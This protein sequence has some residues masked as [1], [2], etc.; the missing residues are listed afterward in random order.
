[1]K[2]KSLY[3]GVAMLAGLLT[4]C[5][6]DMDTPD[7]EVP[8]AT[9][10]AN[11]TILELKQAFEGQTALV[12]NKPGSDEHYIIKGRV[13]SSDASGNIYKSLVLQDE[14]AALTFSLN[15]G[16]MYIDY[17][18]GQEVV[19]DVTGLYLGYYRG[20]QQIGAP[21]DPYKGEKQ[22]GFLAYDIWLSHSQKNGLSNPAWQYVQM[23]SMHP[24]NEYYCIIINDLSDLSGASLPG[25]QSQ[26]VELRNVSW[27]GAGELNYAPYQESVNR[28]LKFA[29][30]Q[31]ID[32]RNSG[33]SNFYNDILPEGTG[34]VRGILSYYGDSWQL[35]LRDKSDV[36]I[37]TAGEKADPFTVE[38]IQ[39]ANFQG[40]EGWT[41]GYI[42]GSVKAGVSGVTSAD[43][44]IFGK[45]AELDNNLVVAAAPEE[46]DITKCYIVELPQGTMFRELGNLVD[47]P[48]NY[49]KEIWIYGTIGSFMGMPGIVDCPGTPTDFEIAGIQIGDGGVIPAAKG[50]GTEANPYNIGF[51]K[52]STGTISSVWV[53]GYVAGYVAAEGWDQ[54]ARFT[55][56]ADMT[57]S[58]YVN[59]SNVILSEQRPLACGLL[60]SVPAQLNAKSRPELSLKRDPAA[61][62]KHVK[63]KCNITDYLGV[64]GI[65]NITEVVVL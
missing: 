23:N 46:K 63:V 18:L 22:L 13:V 36:L 48:D 24:E 11:T 8:V 15:E 30:G 9:L 45:N 49:G 29:S 50:D 51:V 40:R 1:M 38:N 65:R 37:S 12:G 33:Y 44:V 28:Q 52:T 21:S 62:G 59:E 47:N 60:N 31:T 34:N 61:Y 53:E 39:D 5:Q 35:V 3:L 25:M 56:A 19:V 14:T 54:N 4:G 17:R 57:S 26:L 20:L 43:N 41:K 32:V 6:A 55:N 64:R 58:Y 16:S 42:V 7:L 27:V 2:K 10:Q